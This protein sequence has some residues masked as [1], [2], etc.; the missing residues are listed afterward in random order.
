MF[1]A[2]HPVIKDSPTTPLRIVF[3]ASSRPAG[4]KSLN[5]CMHVGPSLTQKLHDTLLKFRENPVVVISDISKAFHRILIDEDH[6]KYTKFVWVTM[7]RAELAC[8]QFK[9]VIF[10]VCSSP[11]TSRSLTYTPF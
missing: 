3:N 9:V 8:Y 4:G 11:Y 7:G 1:L 5:D 6:R 2:Y 10:G